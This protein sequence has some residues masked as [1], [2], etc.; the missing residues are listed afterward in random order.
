MFQGIFLQKFQF[1]LGAIKGGLNENVGG[2]I[3]KFQ[4]QLGAIKGAWCSG[5]KCRLSRFQFQLGAIKGDNLDLIG[6][7][8]A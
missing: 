3:A 5:A 6:P 7:W 4:F 1:Q 8:S 2:S